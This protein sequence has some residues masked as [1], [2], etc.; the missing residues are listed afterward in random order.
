VSADQLPYAPP[1]YPTEP[2]PVLDL[3]VY[4][5][6]VPDRRPAGQRLYDRTS[7]DYDAEVEDGWRDLE[8]DSSS[9]SS[10]REQVSNDNI[11]S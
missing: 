2:E 1:V 10:D 6:T 11:N 3:S 9:S 7:H 8:K 5:V 4:G